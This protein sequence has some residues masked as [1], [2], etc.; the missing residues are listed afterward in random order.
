[1]HWDSKIPSRYK[2]NPILK[3]FREQNESCRIKIKKYME[4]DTVKDGNS[5]V[6]YIYMVVLIM[7]FGCLFYYV[8]QKI[9][10][11]VGY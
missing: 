1:M 6:K 4:H 5:D 8:P 7:S 3:N 9:L 11:N 2:L 10:S